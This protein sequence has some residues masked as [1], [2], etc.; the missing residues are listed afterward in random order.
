VIYSAVVLVISRVITIRFFFYF[1]NMML[2]QWSQTP[3]ELICVILGGGPAA[4]LDS[5]RPHS[6][7]HASRQLAAVAATTTQPRQLQQLPFGRLDEA[8]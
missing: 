7:G 2:I 3:T 8:S 6:R 4:H 1:S 5:R